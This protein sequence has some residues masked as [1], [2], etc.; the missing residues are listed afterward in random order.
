MPSVRVL[1]SNAI[2][3]RLALRRVMRMAGSER[4]QIPEDLAAFERLVIEAVIDERAPQRL[5]LLLSLGVG[6]VV[7]SHVGQRPA[8]DPGLRTRGLDLGPAAPG[9]GGIALPRWARGPAR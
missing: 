8:R 4:E 2:L 6:G 1:R 5:G 7:A 9:G 3:L